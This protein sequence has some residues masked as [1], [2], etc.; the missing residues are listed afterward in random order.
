MAADQGHAEPTELDVPEDPMERIAELEAEL[1]TNREHEREVANVLSAVDE[2]AEVIA[3][4]V[5]DL[6]SVT[7]GESQL[8][9]QVSAET[10][11]LKE[12]IE[13]IARG[14]Q[15]ANE[16]SDRTE[17]LAGTAA[18]SATAGRYDVRGESTIATEPFGSTAR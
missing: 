1:E 18:A 16:A 9:A 3:D 2:H 12:T 7:A 5:D 8:L 10:G 11:E 15:T 13:S 4:A 14:T 17:A 6:S